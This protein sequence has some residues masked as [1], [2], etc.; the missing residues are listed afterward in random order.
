MHTMERPFQC[1]LCQRRFSR[2]DNLAQ[3]IRTHQRDGPQVS[4]DAPGEAD[5]EENVEQVDLNTC[6][7]EVKTVLFQTHFSGNIK[8]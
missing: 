4:L 5:G 2:Q 8:V 3:H 6:E 7:I 1:H